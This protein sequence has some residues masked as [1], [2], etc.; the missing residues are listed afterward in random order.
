MI[1]DLYSK[2]N[3]FIYGQ[4]CVESIIIQLI[5][6]HL[7]SLFMREREILRISRNFLDFYLTK[8]FIFNMKIL[9]N[10]KLFIKLS[11]SLLFFDRPVKGN[12]WICYC[13]FMNLVAKKVCMT[14]CTCLTL[15]ESICFFTNWE[16]RWKKQP[17]RN[18]R[19]LCLNINMILT[20]LFTICTSYFLGFSSDCWQLGLESAA[21][22][23]AS[24]KL[25]FLGKS[26]L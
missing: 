15:P 2:Q 26:K 4:F 7:L 14:K 8:L 17:Q 20:L 3:P 6:N 18:K 9:S 16:V 5:P 23:I 11:L 25:V 1:K 10:K 13:D 24:I 22:K 21:K 12:N 19:L